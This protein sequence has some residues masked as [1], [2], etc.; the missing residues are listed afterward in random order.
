[1]KKLIGLLSVVVMAVVIATAYGA[2]KPKPV[3]VQLSNGQGQSVGSVTI[4]QANGGLNL[5]LDLKNLPPGVHA[6]H[7]HQNAKCEG[8]AFTTA[9]PHFNP[10]GKQHGMDNP[11]GP[12]AGDLPNI[13]IGADGTLKK[14]L[15][16]K[17]VTMGDDSHS[18]FTNG[19]TALVIHAKADDERTDPSGNAGDRIACGTITKGGM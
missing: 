10:E 3:V 11:M 1:M 19:G 14:T 15:M 8:P 6:L 12:H 7:V 18:I 2:T 16:V 5:K 4:S 17:S 9:G 13:T